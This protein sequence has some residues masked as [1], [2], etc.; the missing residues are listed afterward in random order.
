MIG[1][2]KHG[3]KIILGGNV[4]VLKR[5]IAPTIVLQP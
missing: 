2:N 3:G 4:D 5:Y 1:E